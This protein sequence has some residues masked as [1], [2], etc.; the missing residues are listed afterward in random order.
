MFLCM[1]SLFF[2][3][4]EMNRKEALQVHVGHVPWV[5]L[6]GLEKEEKAMTLRRLQEILARKEEQAAVVATGGHVGDPQG[7]REREERRQ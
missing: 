5:S 7:E 3:R 6:A 2:C 1:S 4:N